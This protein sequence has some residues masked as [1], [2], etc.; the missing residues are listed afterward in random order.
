MRVY[1][2]EIKSGD[3]IDEYPL[4]VSSALSRRLKTYGT[5]EFRL[6][7]LALNGAQARTWREDL[8]PWR[9]LFV[10]CDDDDRIIWAGIPTAR[11]TDENP[12]VRFPCVTVEKYLDRRY[13][14]DAEFEQEDQTSVIARTLVEAVGDDVIGIGLDYDTPASG[15]L[16]DRTYFN[17]EDARVLTRVQQLSNVI[18]GFDWTIDVEWA[19]EDHSRVVKIFRT[20]YPNLGYITEDPEHVFSVIAG[21]QGPVTSFSHENQWGDGDAATLVQAVGDGQGEDKPYSV[22]IIDSTREAAGWPRLEERQSKQGVIEDDTLAQYAQGMAQ[23][24]FAGQSVISFDA[25]VD[26]WP[27]PADVTL[28]DSA[29]IEIDTDQLTISQV[30]RIIGYSISPAEGKWTPVIARIGD[31]EGIEDDDAG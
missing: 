20:G 21:V 8:I 9:V 11:T 26:Q 18:K 3:V 31:T 29:R 7:V 22:P 25:L 5:G 14:A 15:V 27:S 16:R 19:D 23:T 28:G 17:D 13:Q 10:A 6:P 12:V 24:Y 1:V 4:E 2:C 30:W